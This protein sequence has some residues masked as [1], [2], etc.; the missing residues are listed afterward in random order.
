MYN[1][2]FNFSNLFYPLI[3]ILNEIREKVHFGF[4]KAKSVT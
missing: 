4:K 3:L 2:I 1:I